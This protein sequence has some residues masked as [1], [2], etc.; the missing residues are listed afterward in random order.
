MTELIQIDSS[1]VKTL[2]AACP[3][4][5]Q[6][7]STIVPEYKLAVRA[8]KHRTFYCEECRLEFSVSL[9]KAHFSVAAAAD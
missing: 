3:R 8:W 7:V 6:T 5:E 4:C 2:E 9:E 1:L